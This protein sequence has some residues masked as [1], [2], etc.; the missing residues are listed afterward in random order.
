LEGIVNR[1]CDVKLSENKLKCYVER[2]EN[3]QAYLQIP[4]GQRNERTGWKRGWGDEGWETVCK[5]SREI[6]SGV[7]EGKL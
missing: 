3:P 6:G 1:M 4:G 7:G 2:K 5:E